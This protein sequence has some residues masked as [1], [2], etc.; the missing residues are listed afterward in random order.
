M[1]KVMHEGDIVFSSFLHCVL[2]LCLLEFKPI[3][4]SDL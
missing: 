1:V 4:T 2:C 3:Q